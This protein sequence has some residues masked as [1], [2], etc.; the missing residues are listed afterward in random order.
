MIG[1]KKLSKDADLDIKQ[2]K[3]LFKRVRSINL[4]TMSLFINFHSLEKLSILSFLLS[5]PKIKST[6]ISKSVLILNLRIN[7][8]YL[9]NEN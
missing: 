5:S 6:K 9:I 4:K 2:F 7:L 8:L 3:Q 1:R